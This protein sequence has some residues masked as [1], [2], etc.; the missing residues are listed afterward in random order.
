[1]AKLARGAVIVMEGLVAI[2]T[3]ENGVEL[4]VP[5]TL[6]ASTAPVLDAPVDSEVIKASFDA[7]KTR[8]K[9]KSVPALPHAAATAGRRTAPRSDWLTGVQYR[10]NALGFGAGPVDGINGPRTKKAVLAFQRAYPPLLTDSI[11]GPRTQAKLVQ[12]CGY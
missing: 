6:A 7:Y 12:V 10:L 8:A 3:N 9:G 4:A 2:E 5:A 11:P 1:M